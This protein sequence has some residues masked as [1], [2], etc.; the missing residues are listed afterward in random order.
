[1]RLTTPISSRTAATPVRLLSMHFSQVFS[2]VHPDDQVRAAHPLH[3]S[4]S[5]A[6][7]AGRPVEGSSVFLRYTTP[8]LYKLD[9]ANPL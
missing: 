8:I 9:L 2:Y 7:S 5:F 6:T 1:M 4:V 3:M